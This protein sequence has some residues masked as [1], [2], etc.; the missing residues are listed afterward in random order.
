M[1]SY[2][3]TCMIHKYQVRFGPELAR[4]TYLA[5]LG[6]LKVQ[7]LKSQLAPKPHDR[8]IHDRIIHDRIIQS[9]WLSPASYTHLPHH[10]NRLF[11]FEPCTLSLEIGTLSLAL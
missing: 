11:A 5:M 7:V 10:I 9:T 2:P 4:G 3:H 1:P 6:P 8:I